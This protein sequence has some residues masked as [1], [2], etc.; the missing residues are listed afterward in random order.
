MADETLYFQ[1][2]MR[3]A[4][5]KLDACKKLIELLTKNNSSIKD[6]TMNKLAA[7]EIYYLSGYIIE[8]FLIYI[9]YRNAGWPED[10]PIT[11]TICHC[12]GQMITYQTGKGDDPNVK[13]I[14]SHRYQGYIDIV[15][16]IPWVKRLQLPYISSENDNEKKD[17]LFLIDKWC[18]KIRY[19]YPEEIYSHIEKKIQ[20][21]DTL[22]K[23]T[24]ENLTELLE[25]CDNIYNDIV[26][27]YPDIRQLNL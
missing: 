17:F 5:C 23:A 1:N 16:K 18:P 6:T 24:I 26:K 11:K 20:Y 25:Y 12:E 21:E 15:R 7:H 13:P 3:V 14:S 19:R 9:I 27:Q 2:Y 22:K 4:K 8:G 10:D